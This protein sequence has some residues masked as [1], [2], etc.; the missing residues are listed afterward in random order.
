MFNIILVYSIDN[1]HFQ[2]RDIV[3]RHIL[4]IEKR[5]KVDNNFVFYKY[6]LKLISNPNPNPNLN[7]TEYRLCTTY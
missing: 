3:D 6:A 7:H 5:K 2:E 1:F 4:K